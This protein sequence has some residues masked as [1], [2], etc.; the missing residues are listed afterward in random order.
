MKCV[1]CAGKNFIETNIN[2]AEGVK[3][4]AWKCKSC[5]EMLLETQAAKKALLLNKLRH[6]VRVKIGKLGANL[7][8]R[9]PNELTQLIGLKKG[10]EVMLY[11]SDGKKVVVTPA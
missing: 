9:F 8:M 4:I 10:S 1:K 6:G 11:P 7:V 5:G 3:A 2:L